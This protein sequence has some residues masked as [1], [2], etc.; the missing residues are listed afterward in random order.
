MGTAM[1]LIDADALASRLEHLLSEAIANK[2]NSSAGDYEK[3]GI[4]EG[5]QQCI[6]AKRL[7]RRRG[8]RIP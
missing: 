3:V 8:R 4:V 1:C 6:E 7:L 5:I 2:K